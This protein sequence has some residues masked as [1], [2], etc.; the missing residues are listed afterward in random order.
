V[1]IF[2]YQNAAHKLKKLNYS[3]L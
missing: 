1:Y 3:Q 2:I